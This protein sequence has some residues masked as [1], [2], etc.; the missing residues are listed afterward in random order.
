MLQEV[1]R[2]YSSTARTISPH[3]PLKKSVMAKR[4]SASLRIFCISGETSAQ[5]LWQCPFP[6]FGSQN[7]AWQSYRNSLSASKQVLSSCGRNC[8]HDETPTVH[9]IR[10]MSPSYF[11]SLRFTPPLKSY[12]FETHRRYR[13]WEAG[14]LTIPPAKE[15][16]PRDKKNYPATEKSPSATSFRCR[17]FGLHTS[18][19]MIW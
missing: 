13:F 18:R 16:H 17:F 6:P 15:G 2:A 11:A 9:V 7:G 8:K 5:R 12:G 19:P 1:S 10:T 4:L 14:E 3:T